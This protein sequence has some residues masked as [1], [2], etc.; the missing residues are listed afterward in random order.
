MA[1]SIG[2]KDGSTIRGG[3]EPQ[4]DRL[5][6]LFAHSAHSSTEWWYAVGTVDADGR[7]LSQAQVVRDV[8]AEGRG[9]PIELACVVGMAG[10]KDVQPCD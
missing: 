2:I 7:L 3:G 9:S 1:L 4:N 5:W 10:P 6:R 8:I